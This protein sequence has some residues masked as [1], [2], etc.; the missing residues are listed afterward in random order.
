MFGLKGNTPQPSEMAFPGEVSPATAKFGAQWASTGSES[1][2][3]GTADL[4]P[5]VKERV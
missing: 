1:N 4:A 3:A 2:H 5:P